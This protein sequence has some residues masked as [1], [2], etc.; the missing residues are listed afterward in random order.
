M[1]QLY[2]QW[3]NTGFTDIV[4]NWKK[5]QCN[6]LM[7]SNEIVDLQIKFQ[8]SGIFSWVTLKVWICRLSVSEQNTKTKNKATLAYN[9]NP[10]IL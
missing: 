8:T 2:Q 3:I 5:A 10:V 6:K 9:A 4:C 7:E 1:L